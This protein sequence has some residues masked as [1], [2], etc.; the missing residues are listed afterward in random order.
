MWKDLHQLLFPQTLGG[1]SRRVSAENPFH[2]TLKERRAGEPDKPPPGP[3]NLSGKKHGNVANQKWEKQCSLQCRSEK[4]DCGK[5]GRVFP[6][7]QLNCR[8]Y[9]DS[10]P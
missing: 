7:F 3:P 6:Q 4:T 10:E 1:L 9:G 8:H 2:V 5:D